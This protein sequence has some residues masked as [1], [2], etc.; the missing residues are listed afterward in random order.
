MLVTQP[1]S[2]GAPGP[3]PR[4][5]PPAAPEAS[6]APAP[7]A[8]E[9]LAPGEVERIV[10]S[11]AAPLRRLA[12]WVID[13]GCIGAVTAVFV[14]GATAV[15]APKDVALLESL[16]SVALPAALL[17]ALLAFVY[18]TLFAF[19]FR[20][21]TPGRRLLGIFLVDDSGAA[22]GPARALVRAA[23]ALVSFALFLAGFW[24]ALFDRRGQTLHDKLTRTFVV[25]LL[26]A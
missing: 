3:R 18:T 2:P 20:G 7:E 11:P 23:L 6:A 16:A 5:S 9:A 19:F 25:R 8:R 15:I 10:A 4:A 13:L 21:R 12:A 14:L 1:G 22:P 26:D 24:L 17:A